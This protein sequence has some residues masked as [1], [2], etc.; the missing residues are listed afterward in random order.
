[1]TNHLL[2]RL[3]RWMADGA[4]VATGPT[5]SEPHGFVDCRGTWHELDRV[6]DAASQG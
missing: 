2:V 6:S 5:A 3:D 4:P 1:M